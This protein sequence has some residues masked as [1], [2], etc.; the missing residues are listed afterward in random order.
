M[1]IN[2]SNKLTNSKA[3]AID[4]LISVELKTLIRS[5]MNSNNFHPKKFKLTMFDSRRTSTLM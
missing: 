4:R 5:P 1:L 2:I 3:R